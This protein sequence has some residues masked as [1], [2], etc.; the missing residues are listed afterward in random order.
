L[1]E[2]IGEAEFFALFHEFSVA[3]IFEVGHGDALIEG[4]RDDIEEAVV[5]EVLHDGP[6]GLVEMIQSGE[7][8]DIA[9]ASDVEFGVERA[10]EVE[11]IAGVDLVGPFSERHMGQVQEPLGVQVVGKDGEVFREMF[12]GD[13]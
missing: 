4:G 3:L 1:S 10:T 8:A 6:S 2:L 13:A 9:E 12:D 7:M 5:V 11:S